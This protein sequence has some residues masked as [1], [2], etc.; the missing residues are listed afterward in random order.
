MISYLPLSNPVSPALITG[1]GTCVLNEQT[2]SVISELSGYPRVS[3]FVALRFKVSPSGEKPQ[4]ET[5]EH[6]RD[7]NAV[8]HIRCVWYDPGQQFSHPFRG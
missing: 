8:P 1:T 6:S 7:V 3:P 5:L 2:H 4:S